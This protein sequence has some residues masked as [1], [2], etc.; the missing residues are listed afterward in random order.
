MAGQAPAPRRVV[1]A[2]GDDGIRALVRLTLGGESFDV[3]DAT[4]AETAVRAIAQHRPDLIVVA[5]DL[6]GAS[7]IDL[8]RSLKAQ[9]ETRHATVLLLFDKA[10][11]VDQQDGRAAGVDGFLSKPFNAFALLKKVDDLLGTDA[12]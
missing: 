3:A 5:A 11:P 10:A 8:V 7:G 4:D 2:D 9:P 1:V 6:S 12:A